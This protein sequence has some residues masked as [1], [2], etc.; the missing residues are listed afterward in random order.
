MAQ[1]QSCS[2]I[3]F[4]ILILL[5]KMSY[6]MAH[7]L[8]HVDDVYFIICI[9]HRHFHISR[10]IFIVLPP[11]IFNCFSWKWLVCTMN[12]RPGGSYWTSYAALAV[13]S[14]HSK[15]FRAEKNLFSV[16]WR[17]YCHFTSSTIIFIICLSASSK[18]RT[19]N[20]CQIVKSVSRDWVSFIATF[21]KILVAQ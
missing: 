9:H 20:P 19:W 16:L 5:N 15:T 7:I 6:N 13:D 17:A 14:L 21:I 8:M 12:T 11:Y 4:Q 2:V 10:K 1:Y 18:Y 3:G